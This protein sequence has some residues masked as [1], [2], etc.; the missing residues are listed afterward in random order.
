M[1]VPLVEVAVDRFLVAVDLFF[2]RKKRS[3]LVG[4]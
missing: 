1:I 3:F 2:G 4:N